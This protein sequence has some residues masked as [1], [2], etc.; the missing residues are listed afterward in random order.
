MGLRRPVG[1]QLFLSARQGEALGDVL[2][3]DGLTPNAATSFSIGFD[4]DYLYFA[5]RCDEPQMAKLSKDYAERLRASG[6][7]CELF[8][9]EG[10][11]HSFHT[12]LPDAD[13]SVAFW[14]SMIT[15]AKRILAQG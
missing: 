14:N 1:R 9:A 12:I 11:V 5:A 8:V 7:D 10:G 15:F 3:A 4:D 6:V 13:I 2:E